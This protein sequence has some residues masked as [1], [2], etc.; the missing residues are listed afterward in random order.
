MT[1][2]ETKKTR[3]KIFTTHTCKQCGKKFIPAPYHS[4]KVN[5]RTLCSW[6]CLVRYRNDHPSNVKKKEEPK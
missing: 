3:K 2:T 4:Y 1:P 5:G 6:G